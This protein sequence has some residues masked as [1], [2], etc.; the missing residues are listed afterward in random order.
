MAFMELMTDRAFYP[1][2]STWHV[3]P[4]LMGE[5]RPV[6]WLAVDDLGRI[7]A[8][9]FADPQGFAGRTIALTSDVRSLAE[10][11]K[12]WT[13]VRGRSPRRF[14]MPVRLF[15]RVSGLAGPDLTTMW[16]WL[17]TGRVPLDTTPT[18]EILPDA[19]T[20]RDW[21]H[22][23]NDDGRNDGRSDG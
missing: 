8:T 16:R 7:A 1:P 22:R 19:L 12:L 11:R 20:V 14:P 6:T 18:R 17:R 9:A 10:C 2:V 15:E 4:K 21:L 13:E 3:M 23:G 5:E